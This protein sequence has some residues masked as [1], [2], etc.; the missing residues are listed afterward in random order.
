MWKVGVADHFNLSYCGFV[1]EK[2]IRF[3]LIG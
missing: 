2:V 3:Q 1:K